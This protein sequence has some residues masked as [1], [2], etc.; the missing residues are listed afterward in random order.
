MEFDFL[1]VEDDLRMRELLKELLSREGYNVETVE[2]GA[3]AFDS[4]QRKTFDIVITDLRMPDADG[5]S[6]LQ[7]TKELYPDTLVIVI[8]AYGTV[9][10]AIEA[11]KL[12]AYDY[13]QK[14]FDPE[15]LMLTIKKAVDYR[16]LARENLRL[17]SQLETCMAEEL[18]GTSPGMVEVRRLI[19]KIAPLDTTVVIEGETGT[20]KSL[21]A[22]TI[23]RMSKR[24]T[25]K[26]LSINCGALTETLL[27]SELFGHEKG[28][29]T[30]AI[31]QKRGLF[32][33][34]HRGTLFLDEINNASPN[35]QIKLLKAIEE[36]K[37][38]RVGSIEP[39]S[40]D[41][42]IIAASNVP[43]KNE[44]DAGRFRNDLYFR[45][46]VVTITLPPLRERKDDIPLLSYHFLRRYT[47]KFQKEIKGFTTEAMNSLINY[48]WPGNV[49]ELEFAIERAVILEQ[50]EKIT[51]QALPLE[52]KGSSKSMKAETRIMKIED[53]ERELIKECLR[54][55]NGKK[56]LCAK[57]LGISTATLWRKI[58][59][60][61]L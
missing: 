1:V 11:M 48:D 32:E 61:N 8:T 39:I 12:G 51:P 60:Y 55:F 26:F 28:A 27:E 21:V 13:I 17:S 23:H 56:E 31:R 57:T 2:N 24:S 42:R 30:G 47:Q 40:V 15:R 9:D 35:L 5:L 34:A 29:F 22:R 33:A 59:K 46:K 41:V 10:S 44:V 43:L 20:G 18:I 45:L 7:K 49:R 4:L 53:M 58:K 3:N 14:P 38:F 16:R 36:G 37:I 50:A 54:Q 25:E 19:E 6:V 52:I